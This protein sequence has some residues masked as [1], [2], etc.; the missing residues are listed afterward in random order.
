MP[1]Q[2]CEVECNVRA[3]GSPPSGCRSPYMDNFSRSSKVLHI[4]GAYNRRIA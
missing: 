1:L 3:T 2:L 4:T